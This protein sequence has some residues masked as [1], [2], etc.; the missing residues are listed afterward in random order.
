MGHPVINHRRTNWET[1]SQPEN[2]LL[3]PKFKQNCQ[4]SALFR[5]PKSKKNLGRM[6]IGQFWR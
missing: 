1:V 3:N 6:Q 2:D 4:I 5:T